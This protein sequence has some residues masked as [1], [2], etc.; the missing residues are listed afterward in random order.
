MGH[1]PSVLLIDDGELDRVQE[2]L[3]AMGADFLRVRGPAE[4]ADDV[5]ARDVLV[6]S[7]PRAL[8]GVNLGPAEPEAPAPIWIVV[9][10]QDFLPLRARLRGMGAHYLVHAAAEPAALRLLFEDLLFSGS[11]RRADERLPLA[12]Q[13]RFRVGLREFQAK[14][15]EISASGASFLT[16]SVPAIDQPLT[17]MLPKHIDAPGVALPAEVVRCQRRATA[18]G[19]DSFSVAVRFATVDAATQ[20]QLE[21]IVGG[22]LPGT[23]VTM[24]NAPRRRAPAE[25]AGE[26]TQKIERRRSPRRPFERQLQALHA[27][28]SRRAARV[29]ARDLSLHGICIEAEP[30][31]ALGARLAL[32][33]RGGGAA[34]VVEARLVRDDGSSGLGLGLEFE[35]MA[36]ATRAALGRLIEDLPQRVGRDDDTIVL[37]SPLR[38]EDDTLTAATPA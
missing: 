37:S 11:E 35:P 31:L 23:R 1:S 33:L 5:Q 19:A 10:R 8:G 13:T 34:L 7:W 17:L 29:R 3:V 16:S 38:E 27:R 26:C 6:T 28:D 14:L 15:L 32:A 20:G 30:G 24:L 36:P 12:A 2:V 22:E 21:R 4:S 18:A 9:H 25:R